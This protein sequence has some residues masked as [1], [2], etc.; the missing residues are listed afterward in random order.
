M[1]ATSFIPNAPDMRHTELSSLV[2]WKARAHLMPSSVRTQNTSFQARPEMRAVLEIFRAILEMFRL[3]VGVT[4]RVN[5]FMCLLHTCL[6][7]AGHEEAARP[8]AAPAAMRIW[9]RQRLPLRLHAGL[10]AIS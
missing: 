6:L 7:A 9:I 4:R 1:A 2:P 3:F 5:A 10:P 8:N